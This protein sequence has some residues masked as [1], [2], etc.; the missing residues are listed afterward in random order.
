MKRDLVYLDHIHEAIERI[1]AYSAVGREEF[2]RNRMAQD[3]VVRNFEIIGEAVKRLSDDIK[4][5][6][7]DVP[8]R[9]V[10]GFRNVLVH[11]YMNVD[12][13]E[14]WNVVET[15]LPALRKAVEELLES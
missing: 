15:H 2:F 6:R 10:A 9:R 13:E 8:W 12:Q 5:R 7:P 4:D 14:V 3:A 11:D 1:T